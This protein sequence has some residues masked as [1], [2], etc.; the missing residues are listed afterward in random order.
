M[1][2]GPPAEVGALRVGVV[3]LGMIGSGVVKSL[4]R[5]GVTATAYDIDPGK[6]PALPCVGAASAAEVAAG[7][8]VVLLA[9]VD[10]A[11][12]REVLFG[13]GGIA[14]GARPGL[15]VALLS[16]VSVE[17]VGELGE[18]ATGFGIRLLDCGVTAGQNAATNGLVAMVGGDAE[19]AEEAM[20]A[21]RA[22]AKAAIYCGPLGAGM[23][24]KLVRN[25]VTYGSWKA[26]Y[27]AAGLARA[28]GVEYRLLKEVIEEADPNGETMLILMALRGDTLAEL[29][30]E[31]QD[32]L[33]K[34]Y[35]LMVKD[36]EGAREL[37]EAN[38]FPLPIVDD[39]IA[40]VGP[41][42]FGLED[43][44]ENDG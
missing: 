26:V 35:D 40:G 6:A 14:D 25:F 31:K 30:E 11:Q 16:T 21:L 8:D 33:R 36:L 20:P 2:A 39:L 15:I 37:G 42:M 17:A 4:D 5:S 29:S 27:D 9:V 22:F 13:A 3:G 12:A 1:A 32:E 41:P 34:F 10:A 44:V 38:D 28:A 19:T 7:S 18:L 24:A 43:G 23:A